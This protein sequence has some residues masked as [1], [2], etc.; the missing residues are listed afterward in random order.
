MSVMDIKNL[1]SISGH[2]TQRPLSNTS[3]I[4]WQLNH[5]AVIRFARIAAIM[6]LAIV[7]RLWGLNQIGFNT[8]EA[9]YSGQAA[10]IAQSP[11]LKDIFPVFRAHPLLFQFSLALLFKFGVSD[12]TARLL[13]VAIGVATV[14]VVYRLG[15]LLYGEGAGILAALIMAAMPYHVIVTRQVLLDGPMVLFSTLTLYLLARYALT[16]RSVWLHAVGIGMGL[17]FLAKETGLI[18]IGAVYAFFALA[19]EIN[20]RVRDLV[21]SLILMIVIMLPFPLSLIL[22]GGS[23][24]GGQYLVWQLFRRPNHTWDFYFTTV[25]G[26]IGILVIIVALLGLWLLRK[27]NTWREKLL[28][29]WILVPV[30]FFQIWPTK[31]F[32]YLLP[33]A[34]ALAVLAGRMLTHWP[35]IYTGNSPNHSK[36]NKWISVT[37]GGIMILSLFAVSWQT[38][39][40]GTSGTF[41]AG[42]GGVP[43]GR[44][45]GEWIQ[46][47]IPANATLLTI[48]PSMA[49]II[50]FYGYR[51]AYGISVSPNP[52]HRNP[53][54][55]P[56]NNPNLVLRMGDIQYL[57]WDSYS[58]ERS[59][60]FS[61]RLLALAA[62]F[63]GRVIH[64]E[65]VLVTSE[66]GTQ[67]S[68]PVI[69]IYMVHP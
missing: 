36:N 22:A 30:V 51:K 23:K 5:V 9:V 56:I 7:L 17:T 2:V 42:T 44:E 63:N 10:A 60:F 57:V 69:V 3:A 28:V 50:E 46:Q 8:D 45:A 4:W 25:P 53:S 62:R 34:P 24:V 20:V 38:I 21:L 64:T 32:Q 40:P 26:A 55:E 65:S 66:N 49:N 54:Y 68:K 27:Q 1:F 61:E 18:L 39:Q 31:G 37:I 33:V 47:N 58:A 67:I 11:I 52:L 14:Y 48:G 43:G 15:S 19:S 41:L 6:A 59:S 29:W 13:A 12:L 16:E 35:S